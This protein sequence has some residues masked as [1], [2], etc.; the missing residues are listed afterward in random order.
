MQGII[1]A[2]SASA[3]SF[4]ALYL[5]LAR[6]IR[7]LVDPETILAQI[8]REVEEL[9]VELNGT[10]ERNIT[11]MEQKLATINGALRRVEKRLAVLRREAA[12][13]EESER[14]YAALRGPSDRPVGARA[15]LAPE[16]ISAQPIADGEGAGEGVRE[17]VVSLH[18]AGISPES[19]ARRVNLPRAKVELIV[20]L[21]QEGEP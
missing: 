4:A 5:L 13:L 10:T 19:I 1:V 2:L 6:R 20:S 11:L 18:R 17:R 12:S 9:I 21:E 16:P 7:M 15:E 8:R 3:V 14:V